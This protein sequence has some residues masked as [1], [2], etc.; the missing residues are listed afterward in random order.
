MLQS[1][2]SYADSGVE[3]Q[4]QLTVSRFDG[5]LKNDLFHFKWWFLLV[6]F[7][8]VAYFWWKKVDKSRFSE[9]CLFTAIITITVLILDELGE[10]L[11]LW[12]YPVDL[13]P[14]FPP[15]SSVD[16]A[17]LP[18][19]YSLIYQKF[20]TWKSY[21]IATIIMATVFCFILEPLI[22]LGGIYKMLK[23]KS[24]YGFPIYVLIG[25]GS[26]FV[27]KALYKQKNAGII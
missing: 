16:L 4:W 23:W 18:I 3:V 24:F 7:L 5:W 13:I 21:I 20:R 27:M 10:E 26:K 2:I 17:S 1:I 11:T 8:V 6:Q 25:I 12:D 15:L 19:I 22:S 9:I 14:L